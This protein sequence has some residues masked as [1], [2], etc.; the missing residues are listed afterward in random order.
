[1]DIQSRQ[2]F[3]S[4]AEIDLIES[5]RQVKVM[6]GSL[7]TAR[8]VIDGYHSVWFKDASNIAESVD[9]AIKALRICNRQ[10]FGGNIAAEDVSTYF[11]RNV[12]VPFLD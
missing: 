5:L 2:Q 7:Q 3:N 6:M 10:T 9:A 12:A 11:K 1:M 8:A 4:R